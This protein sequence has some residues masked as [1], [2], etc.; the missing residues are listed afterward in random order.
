L[1]LCIAALAVLAS[2][3]SSA[4]GFELSRVQRKD[5]KVLPGANGF[6]NPLTGVVSYSPQEW[7]QHPVLGIKVGNSHPERPQAGLDRADV[8]Y[9]ELV[10]GGET[11]FLALF[12]TNQ[13][14]RVGPVR[15]V[16]TVDHKILRPLGAL[17]GYS[18]GVP[19]IVSDLRR[20]PGVTDVGA[21]RAADAYYRSSVRSAPYNL[22]TATDRLWRGHIGSPPKP[23]FSF[24]SSSDDASA[25]GDQAANE[26]KFSFAGNASAVR[27]EYDH[28]TGRYQRF[29]GDSPQLVEG[30]SHGVQLAFRNV[31]VQIVQVS[32]GSTIDRAGD[33]SRDVS[34]IGSGAAVL[35]RGGRAFRGRWQRSSVSDPTQFVNASGSP[36]RLAPGETVVELLPA[37][38][39]LF[40]S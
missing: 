14:P 36:L 19:P 12:L 24:L 25:G 28:P 32:Q 7:Q 16:R 29:S 23:Q 8:I 1:Y 21:D 37:A 13:A 10:E 34:M 27:Y 15:S 5:V 35:F 11:R 20:T 4:S 18:G 39:E 17:F 9:E 3:C 40:V 2:A 22:Y 6:T 30:N 33:R 26:V 31:L 38:R